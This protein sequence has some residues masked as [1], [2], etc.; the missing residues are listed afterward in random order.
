MPRTNAA[1]I[2]AAERQRQ[3]IQLRSAGV[4]LKEIARQLGYASHSGARRAILAGLDRALA[5]T[6]ADMR[7]IEGARLD[8]LWAAVWEDFQRGSLP[9][10]DRGIK[11]MARRAKLFGLDLVDHGGEQAIAPMRL[12]IKRVDD[13]SKP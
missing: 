1:T 6:V 2:A 5:D 10:I 13:P 3:A 4:T 12:I 8:E 7:A 11:I 9:A